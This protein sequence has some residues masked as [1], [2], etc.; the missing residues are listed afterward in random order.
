M[1]GHDNGD[2][3]GD[4]DGQ[5]GGHG[6]ELGGGVGS[7]HGSELGGGVGSGHGSE[8]GGGVGTGHGSGP[9][10]L[11]GRPRGD[12]FEL[13][14]REWMARGAEG[15]RPAAAPYPEIVRRGRAEQRR[16]RL[17]VA[18]A[19]LFV[20]ALVPAT[21]LALGADDGG[22]GASTEQVSVA[23]GGPGPTTTPPSPQPPPG[24][25]APATPGQLADGITLQEAGAWLEMCLDEDRRHAVGSQF[26]RPDRGRAADYRIL[27]SQRSTG[28]D[29]SPGDGQTVVAVRDA[30]SQSRIICTI[31]DGRVSGLNGSNGGSGQ[32]ENAAVAPDVNAGKLHVQRLRS[33]GAWTLPY[34]WGGVGTVAPD[35]A[36]LTVSYGGA[37]VEAAIDRGWY[38]ATGILERPVTTA[39]RVQAYDARGKLIYDSN[40]DDGYDKPLP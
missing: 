36:R 2:G 8:L 7:G 23:G 25:A 24:P 32:P 38:A 22:A 29:N 39:P 14:L 19:A 11:R 15:L 26:P 3:R 31:K 30:P 20:L 10:G 6:S 13:D 28:N 18:G 35:V 12:E 27:L 16:R 4:G 17:S 40:L 21:A 5:G 37:T 34:R 33:E 9:H 1:N